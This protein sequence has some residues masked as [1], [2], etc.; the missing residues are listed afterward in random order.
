MNR[1]V[2]MAKEKTIY[3]CQKCAAQSPKWMGRCL[4][5]GEWN[6]Y[7]EETFAAGGPPL[8]QRDR[9]GTNKPQPVT[10][11][12]AEEGKHEPTKIP[13]LDRVLGGGIVPGSAILVGGEPGIG[14]ST[15][16]LEMLG[17]L[18]RQGKKVLYMS[19]EESASQIK[20]RATR[21][22]IDEKNLFIATENC[23]ELI[24]D[25]LKK[26]KPHVVAIDSIQTVYSENLASSPGTVSQLRE[27][28]GRLISETKKKNLACFLVGH[29][30]KDGAIAGPKVLEHMVDCVLYFETDQGHSYRILR[31]VKNR[32]GTTNEIGVFEMTG[33]G[34][35]NVT[36]PSELFL[37]ERSQSAAGSAVVA[38]LEGTRPLLM[39]IQAL[40]SH[41][42]LA[43]PRR[44]SI[45]IDSSRVSLLVAV[46]EKIVGLH[47][48]DQDI[49]VNVAGGLK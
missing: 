35:K 13:E 3:T 47:L 36:N 44:T 32:F 10:E 19:G 17:Q 11:I 7:V 2:A 31:A 20:A 22:G 18:A 43:N 9:S 26:E 48:S 23:L 21:L 45:G 42:G 40:V 24:L 30:T 27:A 28:S 15:L 12:S 33:A 4:D 46:L 25:L 39:E 49:F 1:Q 38:S 37:M 14:K 16:L 6:S 34:L 29:V 41:S 8:M 5:C